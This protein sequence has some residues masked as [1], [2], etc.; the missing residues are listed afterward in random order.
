MP[1]RPIEQRVRDD[2]EKRGE[3]VIPPAKQTPDENKFDPK[4]KK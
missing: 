3:T 1:E 4:P 2:D